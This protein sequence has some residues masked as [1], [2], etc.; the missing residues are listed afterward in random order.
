MHL[1]RGGILLFCF[2]FLN[3]SV[4]PAG[5]TYAGPSG[6]AFTDEVKGA[7]KKLS[8]S[9]TVPVSKNDIQVLRQR[10]NHFFTEAERAGKP[11]SYGIGILDREGLAVAGRYITGVFKEEDF[12]KYQ[13]VIRAFKQK[14]T[15]QGRLYLQ[16][17]SGLLIVC[18]P[19][20]RQKEVVGALV[21]GFDPSEIKK[22]HGLTPEQFLAIDFNK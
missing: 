6:Q 21:L 7:I 16:G 14:K 19:L 13:Y 18:V 5:E 22:N 17:G 15:V 10:L 11:V 3:L 8:R 12:S 9:M 20:V 2:L 4:L 1:C